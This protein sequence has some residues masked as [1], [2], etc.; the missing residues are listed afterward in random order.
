[1]VSSLGAAQH[2]YLDFDSPNQ[3]DDKVPDKYG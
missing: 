1:M 3:V 2:Y